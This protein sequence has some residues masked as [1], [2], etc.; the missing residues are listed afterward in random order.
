MERIVTP[1]VLVMVTVTIG[2]GQYGGGVDGKFAGDGL[3]RKLAVLGA[4]LVGG[5]V[6]DGVVGTVGVG[7]YGLVG[8]GVVVSG[9]VVATVSVVVEAGLVVGRV[10]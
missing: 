5:V 1:P 4:A 2:M 6:G 7:T 8:G 9:T 3:R 10:G